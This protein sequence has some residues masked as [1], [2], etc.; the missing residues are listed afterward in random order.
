MCCVGLSP[1]TL[2]HRL[3]RCARS[4]AQIVECILIKRC[5]LLQT[6]IFLLQTTNFHHLSSHFL[7]P[8]SYTLHPNLK[9]YSLTH[10]N[11]YTPQHSATLRLRP[12]SPILELICI[13]FIARAAIHKAT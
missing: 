1:R 6:S 8:S 11:T 12:F 7:H 5:I 9:T 2:Q 13:F 10:F 3:L 4:D